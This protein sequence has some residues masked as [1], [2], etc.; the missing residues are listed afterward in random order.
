MVNSQ[1]SKLRG[2][3]TINFFA[4]DHA[5]AQQWYTD[6]LG[7]EPYFVRPGYAEFR[8]GDYQQELGLIDSKY[9]PHMDTSTARP[10]GAIVYWQ[11]D[12]L[13]AILEDLLS[14]GAQQIEP[15]IERGNGFITASVRDPFG[16][17]IGIMHNVHYL[18]VLNSA[19]KD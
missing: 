8:L 7:M 14:R 1:S 2:V 3:A 15:R 11:V 19:G 17:I 12:D 10:A 4:A 6:W 16:N 13:D 5:A 18:E 9:V